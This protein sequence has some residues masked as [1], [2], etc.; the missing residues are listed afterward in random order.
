MYRLVA[1]VEVSLL[2]IDIHDN[3]RNITLMASLSNI[4]FIDAADPNHFL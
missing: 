4:E 3:P 1:V 2:F